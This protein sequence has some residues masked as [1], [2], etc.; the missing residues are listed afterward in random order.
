VERVTLP[1]LGARVERGFGDVHCG[2]VSPGLG[3]RFNGVNWR[4]STLGMALLTTGCAGGG[5]L[6]NLPIEVAAPRGFALKTPVALKTPEGVRFD[7]ALCRES[8]S[9]APTRI[10]LDHVS[11][12]GALL[13]T[14]SASVTDLE[15][16]NAHC[17]YFNVQTDWTVAEGDHIRVCAP[18]SDAPCAPV[19]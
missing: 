18:R 9:P 19:K 6:L 15:G 3:Q 17:A 1:N 8:L 7:G 5:A 12:S 13:G 2:A 11:A 16:R 10:R 14:R 4:L